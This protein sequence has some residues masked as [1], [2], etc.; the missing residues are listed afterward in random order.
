MANSADPDQIQIS[1]WSGSTLFAKTGYIRVQHDKGLN[2]WKGETDHR[3]YFVINLLENIS[4]SIS[5]KECWWPGNGWPATS[6]SPVECTSNWATDAGVTGPFFLTSTS[7]HRGWNGLVHFS[8]TPTPFSVF[9]KKHQYFLVDKRAWSR[10]THQVFY[11]D[12]QTSPVS[13]SISVILRCLLDQN[14]MQNTWHL[15]CNVIKNTFGQCLAKIQISLHI[16]VWSEST[17]HTFWIAKNAN[18]LHI[19]I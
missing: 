11:S 12:V 17:V 8:P 16:H 18:F 9:I 7:S 10:D 5:K 13:H 14:Q 1:N 15:C 6:W 3:K 2:Q 4:W 19:N